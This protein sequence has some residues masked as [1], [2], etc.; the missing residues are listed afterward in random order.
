MLSWLVSPETYV[1][2]DGKKPSYKQTF[3]I[4]VLTAQTRYYIGLRS[5]EPNN[6]NFHRN[7]MREMKVPNLQKNKNFNDKLKNNKSIQNQK[8]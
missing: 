7:K 6:P 8:Y 4:S 1:L 5:V 2:L 3:V